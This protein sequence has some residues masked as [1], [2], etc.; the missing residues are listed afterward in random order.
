MKKLLVFQLFILIFFSVL[1]P[2]SSYHE[3]PVYE[4]IFPLN[5]TLRL[6]PTLQEDDALQLVKIIQKLKEVGDWNYYKRFHC[7][8][9]ADSK[10]AK[11][12][13]LANM[14]YISYQ[15]RDINQCAY[16]YYEITYNPK[17]NHALCIAVEYYNE[18][19]VNRLKPK[20][21]YY[22]PWGAKVIKN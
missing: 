20:T 6:A 9:Y 4:Q 12:K 5:W 18:R 2:F 11:C 1:L 17:T 13:F 10:Y 8:K 21:F 7:Y 15:Y 14:R 19:W 16:G 22:A 3:N